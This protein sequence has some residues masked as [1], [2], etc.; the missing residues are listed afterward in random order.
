MAIQARFPASCEAVPATGPE[1]QVIVTARRDE[2]V[3]PR[4]CRRHPSTP[5]EFFDDAVVRRCF[6]RSRGSF[7]LASVDGLSLGI[8]A[9]EAIVRTP[10]DSPYYRISEKL[11]GGG[12][13]VRLQ[14]RGH[15]A[16]SRR[17]VTMTWFSGPVPGPFTDAGTSPV[18]PLSTLPD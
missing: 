6:G 7:R 3:C 13:G 5:T 8:N 14:G 12:M 16:S 4:P 2:A 11:G 18:F 15:T 9:C 1:N 10:I 17:A